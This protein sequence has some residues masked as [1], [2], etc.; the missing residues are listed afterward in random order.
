MAPDTIL[1]LLWLLIVLGSLAAW[2]IAE[3]RF[4]N[5]SSRRARF[6]RG[7][8]VLAATVALFPCISASDDLV[9]LRQLQPPS[10][11]QQSLTIT[12]PGQP[13]GG[14]GHYL[15]Q[16]LEVIENFCRTTA[17][18]LTLVLACLAFTFSFHE[19]YSDRSLPS[20]TGRAPPLFS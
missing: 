9:C 6:R 17:N 15:A 8:A 14:A 7:I 3:L 10:Q 13:P 20:P 2:G 11:L 12:T 4:F 1:N 18:P 5:P 16:L 19:L